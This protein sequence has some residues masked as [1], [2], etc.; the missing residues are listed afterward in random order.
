LKGAKVRAGGGEGELVTPTGAAILATLCSSFGEPISF[1]I[2]AVGYGAGTRDP[3]D[4]PNVLRLLVGHTEP[5]GGPA[6]RDT[7]TIQCLECELDDQSP[8]TLAPLLDALLAA[9]AVDAYFTPVVMKKGRPGTLL[10]AL[11]PESARAAV[12]RA[13]FR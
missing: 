12:E 7:D 13:I 4:V 1:E 11:A 9:G 3:K 2:D 10:T 6:E 5:G 8:E